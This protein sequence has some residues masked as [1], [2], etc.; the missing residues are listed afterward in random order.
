MKRS[1]GFRFARAAVTLA[2]AMVVALAGACS[3]FSKNTLTPLPPEPIGRMLVSGGDSS[4]LF[5]TPSYT[6][7][8]PSYDDVW[9][10]KLTLEDVALQYHRLF[11]EDPPPIAIVLRDSARTRPAMDSAWQVPTVVLGVP[12]RLARKADEDRRR[13]SGGNAFAVSRRLTPLAARAW[14]DA[15]TNRKAGLRDSLISAPVPVARDAGA[16]SV[17][18]ARVILPAWFDTG[19]ERLLIAPEARDM[20]AVALQRRQNEIMP[21][22]ALLI[23]AREG[24]PSIAASNDAQFTP[25]MMPG[26]GMSG[27]GS[28]YGTRR[29]GEVQGYRT[30]IAST[31][32][33]TQ[34]TAFVA[35]LFERGGPA[36]M[37]AL[38]AGL[39]NHRSLLESLAARKEL[40]SPSDLAVLE[41]DWLKWLKVTAGKV[42][43]GGND[44]RRR[45]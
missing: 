5:S 17:T 7:V 24:A 25:S 31:P 20:A 44:G 38:V 15:L 28:A 26:G 37:S 1:S 45:P 12:T 27:N 41:A 23:H 39:A 9:D 30:S 10:A 21:L 6:L 14:I 8:A 3:S 34:S 4:V 16:G 29:P 43:N 19:L 32:F 35:Y 2:S 40:Q 36:A 13:Y 33:A 18:P 22:T 11:G 42:N